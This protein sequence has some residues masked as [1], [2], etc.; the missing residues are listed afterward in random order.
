MEHEGEE[1]L[2]NA[3]GFSCSL[4]F[5]TRWNH[6]DFW[7]SDLAKAISA[8]VF[9]PY[10]IVRLYLI[11]PYEKDTCSVEEHANNKGYLF[12]MKTKD[13]ESREKHFYCGVYVPNTK[14]FELIEIGM[15]VQVY[16]FKGLNKIL[17]QF[18]KVQFDK[19]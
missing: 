11:L 3:K 6:E 12:F 19:F 9:F 13:S 16:V 15:G 10:E 7:S 14:F 4:N 1:I 18:P 17:S 2:T 8:N 5:A